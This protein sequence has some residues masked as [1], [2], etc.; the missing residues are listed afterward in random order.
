MQTDADADDDVWLD[1][2]SQW[3]L[4]HQYDEMRVSDLVALCDRHGLLTG[5]RGDGSERSQQTRLGRAMRTMRDRVVSEY[6]IVQLPTTLG[7]H[8]RRCR[9]QQN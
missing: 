2:V 4:F 5:L 8:G 9:L 6:R 3:W 7:H 1:F